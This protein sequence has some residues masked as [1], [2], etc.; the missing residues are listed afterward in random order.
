MSLVAI[1]IL[2][3]EKACLTWFHFEAHGFFHPPLFLF[4]LSTLLQINIYSFGSGAEKQVL[5]Y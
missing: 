4:I 3:D 5:S 2:L 1:F